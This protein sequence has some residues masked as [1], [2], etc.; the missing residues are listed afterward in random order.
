M[1]GDLLGSV[2]L[3]PVLA[4]A[5][6]ADGPLPFLPS[7]PLLMSAVAVAPDAARIAV[8]AAAAFAGSLAGDALLYALGRGSHRFL[9]GR[10]DGT[11]VRRHLH[12]RPILTLVAVRFVPGGRLVSVAA[13]GRVRLPVRRF[14]PA[15]IASSAVWCGYMSGMGL[16][17]APL[18]QG[19]PLWSLAAGIAMAV[20]ISV[21]GEFGRRI[22][23]RLRTPAPAPTRPVRAT[24]P[25]AVR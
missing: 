17:I 25:T 9:R 5:V 23:V 16:L 3:L 20:V 13:A 24:L 15:T 7:E 12:R 18:T 2:W 10:R 8:L 19:D 1:T 21:A 6:L 11:W 14:L 22:V 4:L